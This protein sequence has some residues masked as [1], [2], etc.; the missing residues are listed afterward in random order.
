MS[1]VNLGSFLQEDYPIIV[2]PKL[3]ALIGLNEAIVLQQIKYWIIKNQKD[4]RNFVDGKYWTYNS[5]REWQEQFPFWCEKTIKT[6]I[7]N[8]LDM[9][10]ILSE[11][12]HPDP[13]K[14]SKWYSIS[15]EGIEKFTNR[16]GKNYPMRKMGN[17][18]TQD[19]ETPHFSDSVNITQSEGQNLPNHT[20]TTTY[21]KERE[22]ENQN[23]LNEWKKKTLDE[24]QPLHSLNDDE[25][26]EARKEFIT[27]GEIKDIFFSSIDKVD[28]AFELWCS[29]YHS[30]K[31]RYARKSTSDSANKEPKAPKV[32][33]NKWVDEEINKKP[34]DQ[35]A[36]YSEIR[37]KLG[38]REFIKAAIA[39]TEIE[40]TPDKIVF[41]GRPG[42]HNHQT[43]HKYSDTIVD[44]LKAFKPQ[45]SIEFLGTLVKA[46]GGSA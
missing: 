31:G 9:E 16:S 17:S 37:A 8:L 36:I 21:T 38:D 33:L 6:I 41:K 15:E 3:A 7:K 2:F 42:V 13:F 27:S 26:V 25:I 22:K 46:K 32:D 20:E 40:M 34:E 43:L 11:N 1:S 14:K 24:L 4:G 12:H 10:L 29:R 44:V 30:V 19:P 35:R 45:S 39:I 5:I 23:F 18:S 28:K